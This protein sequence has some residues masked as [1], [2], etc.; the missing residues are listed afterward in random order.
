MEPAFSAGSRDFTAE[1]RWASLRCKTHLRR[2]C[3]ESLAASRPAFWPD[4]RK[5]RD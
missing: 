3:R 1:F 4:N 2:R 5:D